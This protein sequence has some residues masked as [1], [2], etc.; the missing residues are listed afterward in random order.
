M[1]AFLDCSPGWH[2]CWMALADSNCT[3]DWQKDNIAHCNSM[4]QGRLPGRAKGLASRMAQVTLVSQ[5]LRTALC[6]HASTTQ[7]SCLP[8]LNGGACS[9]HAVLFHCR[10]M[11]SICT[12]MYACPGAFFKHWLVIWRSSQV[13]MS[14]I[15]QRS[16]FYLKEPLT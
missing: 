11:T 10:E 13:A 8:L 2:G 1:R 7:G 16:V 14:P 9:L 12:S 15:L 3:T 6:T 4:L 5:Q